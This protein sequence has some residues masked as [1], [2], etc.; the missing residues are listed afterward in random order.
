MG[1]VI[2]LILLAAFVVAIIT[3]YRRGLIRSVMN[4]ASFII[5][6]FCTRN[7]TPALAQIYQENFMFEA[8]CG[9]IQ[10][11]LDALVNAGLQSIDFSKLFAEKPAALIDIADRFGMDMS[12]LENFYDVSASEGVEN[13][14]RSLAEFI[15]EPAA[16]TASE[17]AAF[18]SI[19]FGVLLILFLATLLLDLIFKLPL[20]KTVNRIGGIA[21]GGICGLAYV[22]ILAYI[23][24]AAVP[25][26]AMMFPDAI[27]ASAAENSMLLRLVTRQ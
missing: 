1:I 14:S 9:Q 12:R 4:I 7:F 26:L 21:I 17:V 5:A 11:S 2:D 16:L 19:F 25:V 13:M 3:G 22:W 8:F 18:V 6:Y 20:L 24:S 27:S 23:L 15:A 10:A